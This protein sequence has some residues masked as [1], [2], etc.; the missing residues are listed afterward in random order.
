MSRAA[1]HAF[2]T[3]DEQALYEV[4][5]KGEERLFMS[6]IPDI[7]RNASGRPMDIKIEGGSYGR[8]VHSVTF[9]DRLHL[10][11]PQ[12]MTPRGLAP[13]LPR[14]ARLDNGTY[15]VR[16]KVDATHRI[17]L[18]G[19]GEGDNVTPKR[20]VTVEYAGKDSLFLC[21]LPVCVQGPFCNLTAAMNTDTPINVRLHGG[22]DPFDV[23][24]VY[25][26]NGKDKA[27]MIHKMRAD[28]VFLYD[29]R[30][31][32]D[33]FDWSVEI[34]SKKVSY[35]NG[36]GFIVMRERR[37]GIV[38]VQL[39][40]ER[41]VKERIPIGVI[42]RALGAV[43]AKEIMEY[44]VGDTDAYPDILMLLAASISVKCVVGGKNMK[45]KRKGAAPTGP[46]RKAKEGATTTTAAA[47]IVS[48]LAAQ[49]AVERTIRTQDEAIQYISDVIDSRKVERTPQELAAFTFK[50]I[51]DHILPHCGTNADSVLPKLYFLGY[52][53]RRLCFGITGRELPDN[54]DAT[55][56]K[57][58]LPGCFIWAMLFRELLDKQLESIQD[59]LKKQT[60]TRVTEDQDFK[61]TLLSAMRGNVIAREIQ[62]VNNTGIF[63]V[64]ASNNVQNSVPGMRVIELRSRVEPPSALRKSV[65]HVAST[66][67]KDTLRSVKA[68]EIGYLDPLDTP[69]GEHIGLTEHLTVFGTIALG[70]SPAPVIAF[71]RRMAEQKK[72]PSAGQPDLILLPAF[73]TLYRKEDMLSLTPIIVNNVMIAFTEFPTKVT[74][75]LRDFRRQGH[76]IHMSV[77]R[78]FR[79]NVIKVSTGGGRL[80]RP[81]FIVKNG[82]FMFTDA[83]LSAFLARKMSFDDLLR[84]G[85]VEYVDT[86][87]AELNCVATSYVADI[88]RS[89]PVTQPY[90]HCEL[91][92]AALLSIMTA[93]TPGVHRQP[94]P[95]V[96]Y[97]IAQKKQSIAQPR[98]NLSSR[99]DKFLHF[100][101]YTEYPLV[102]SAFTEYIDPLIDSGYNC[103]VAILCMTRNQE[104]SI[105]LNKNATDCGLGLSI[106]RKAY[107]ERIDNNTRFMRPPP[108]ETIGMTVGSDYNNLMENGQIPLGTEV[109]I[110]DI[111]IGKVELLTNTDDARKEKFRD[112]SIKVKEGGIV[113]SVRVSQSGTGE[114]QNTTM[115]ESPRPMNKGD[116]MASDGAQKG[117]NSENPRGVDM[118]FM[119]DGTAPHVVINPHAF[120][121]RMTMAMITE[122]LAGK[123]A[124]LVGEYVDDTPFEITEENF[125]DIY[126]EKM[127]KLGFEPQGME[128]MYCGTTGRRMQAKIFVG[129][130]YYQ[131]LKHM[132][133]DKQHAR[134]T[135]LVTALT[136]QPVPGR[137]RDGAMRCGEMETWAILSHGASQMLRDR[138]V[139]NSDPYTVYVCGGCR[140]L[141]DGNKEKGTRHCRMCGNGNQ[142][143]PVD[144]KYASRLAAH[145]FA[146]MNVFPQFAV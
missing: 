82:R 134:G 19:K 22:E 105:V 84:A 130:A 92:P 41:Y 99:Q 96:V 91:H 71:L 87:E 25:I 133:F 93:S 145:E 16:L 86:R 69:D 48:P 3:R 125:L 47:A 122:M 26:I 31:K 83:T 70:S 62:T 29:N 10:E 103:I 32:K 56:N 38:M 61:G 30:A 74:E 128:D 43:T 13:M 141:A 8:A 120:P 107:H 123:Y 15:E 55:Q 21:A 144:M 146:T 101:L 129:Q 36:K 97:M 88:V 11:R 54:I 37:S 106:C 142:V 12:K 66:N 139:D 111:V 23:C 81:M 113:S 20:V 34:K 9:G 132:V 46:P 110:G 51:H 119:A 114:L 131:K 73:D 44:I 18:Y 5:V 121:S 112:M 137:A 42:F 138:L 65:Q 49:S 140:H 63:S 136:R 124:G 80:T 85:I 79:M 2:F 143:V 75:A 4:V 39:G 24:P 27:T 1:M 127:K 116:K 53:V 77:A 40:N 117:I 115:I 98:L 100:G 104:D 35:E 7:I 68:G 60:A 108:T 76:D 17:E 126:T 58:Y 135:G 33:Q 45:K 102:K 78:D 52:M 109:G 50:T 72:V 28:E 118:P 14:D 94:A 59:N 95:R 64:R 57:A 67:K 90:T 89:D 6:F